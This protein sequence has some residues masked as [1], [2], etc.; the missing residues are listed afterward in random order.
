MIILPIL[1]T[2]LI[3]LSLKGRENVLFELGS[4]KVTD[5]NCGG[6]SPFRLSVREVDKQVPG[7]PCVLQKFSKN[8]SLSEE[9]AGLMVSCH[10]RARDV[11]Y[12]EVFF[13]HYY[14][15]EG[16]SKQGFQH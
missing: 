11:K 1:T 8:G 3:H 7:I 2:S 10:S 6:M 9:A 15:C 16:I 4:E 12:R 13:F 5:H 14:T